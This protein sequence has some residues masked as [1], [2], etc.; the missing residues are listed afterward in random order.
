MKKK[1]TLNTSKFTDKQMEVMIGLF[2]DV[3]GSEEM[4]DI[5]LKSHEFTIEVETTEEPTY[6]LSEGK[7][8]IV[9]SH[10]VTLDD[11][12]RN[13]E[14]HEYHIE[15]RLEFIDQLIEWIAEADYHNKVMMKAD[16]EM[17]MDVEDDFMLSSNS[18]NSYLIQGDT[19]FNSTCAELIELN[20]TL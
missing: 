8:L 14:L 10:N 3:L 4:E 2:C 18:T 6:K 1:F 13:E 9:G 17:L 15:N 16:L 7:I 11:S 12:I 5:T 19:E 20:E